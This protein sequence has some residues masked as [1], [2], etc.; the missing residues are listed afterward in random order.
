METDSYEYATLYGDA[1]ARRFLMSSTDA[2]RLYGEKE[3]KLLNFDRASGNFYRLTIPEGIYEEVSTEALTYETGEYLHRFAQAIEDHE[4]GLTKKE[5]RERKALLGERFRREVVNHLASDPK[6]AILRE[7]LDYSP[8]LIGTPDGVFCLSSGEYVTGYAA[9]EAAK[10]RGEDVEAAAWEG[11]ELTEGAYITKRTG[12][13]PQAGETPMFDS[14]LYDMC[15]GDGEKVRFLL[16]WFGYCLTPSTEEQRFLFL[17]GTGSNG[18]DTL[19]NIVSG[20]FGDYAK[21]I[22]PST[23]TQAKF[24]QHS[25]ALTDLDGPR[26]ATV[27]ESKGARWDLERLKDVTGGAQIVARRM[28]QDNYSF[29]V[30]AKLVMAGNSRPKFNTDPAIERRLISMTF[31]WRVPEDK[32]MRGFDQHIIKNEGPQILHLIATYGYQQWRQS[33][34]GEPPSIKESTK[35]HFIEADPVREFLTPE[36]G[37][38]FGFEVTG[39][40][41]DTIAGSDLYAVYRKWAEDSGFAAPLTKRGFTERAK[42]VAPTVGLTWVAIPTISDRSGKQKRGFRGAKL[43]EVQQIF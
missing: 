7:H 9:L 25:T 6:R 39:E 29:P 36:V 4:K 22:A 19:L 42:A 3:G 16:R 11:I 27:G 43:L 38:A 2:A 37:E 34:L 20:V 31:D 12:V 21:A 10:E 23:F 26:L 1:K 13:A 28:R 18:K 15:G 30:R 41:T 17:Y 14:L 33:G 8:R 5:Q 24:E 40:D 32:R 35:A